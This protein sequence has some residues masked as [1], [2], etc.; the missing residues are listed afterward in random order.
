MNK[1]VNGDSLWNQFV[2]KQQIYIGGILEDF[3]DSMDNI[4]GLEPVTTNITGIQINPNGDNSFFFLI[5]GI[6]FDCGFDIGYGGIVEGDMDWITFCGY[7]NHRFRI[8]KK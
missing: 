5:K 6:D 2:E 1:N 8:K 7:G 4:L 3:G